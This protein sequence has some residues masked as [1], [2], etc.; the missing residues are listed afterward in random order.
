MRILVLAQGVKDPGDF[1]RHWVVTGQQAV[2]HEVIDVD[3]YAMAAVFGLHGME[4]V[5]LEYARAYVPDVALILP[6]TYVEARVCDDLR[7]LGVVLV[8]LRFDDGLQI[9]PG[10]PRLT[11]EQVRSGCYLDPHC[12]L[13]ITTCRQAVEVCGDAGLRA[14]R[15]GRLPIGW[16]AFSAVPGPVHPAITFIGQ[17]KRGADGDSFRIQA[18]RALLAAGLPV[19]VYGDEWREVPGMEAVARPTLGLA[20]MHRLFRCSAVSLCLPGKRAIQMHSMLKYR[21]LEIAACGGTQVTDW[22]PELADYFDVE[23]DLA[24]YSDLAGLV[25]QAGHYLA[26]P[27]A[28]AEKGRRARAACEAGLGWDRW[29]QDVAA[30]LQDDGITLPASSAPAVLTDTARAMLA[31]TA[32]AMGH[33]HESRGETD[34][35]IVYFEEALGLVPE[36]HGALAGLAR[37]AGATVG[38]RQLWQAATRSSTYVRPLQ[39]GTPFGLQG[40]SAEFGTAFELQAALHWFMLARQQGELEEAAAA[41]ATISGYRP[42]FT[43]RAVEQWVAA[44]HVRVAIRALDDLLRVHPELAEAWRLRGRVHQMTGNSVAARLDI[45]QA[46]QLAMHP[47]SYY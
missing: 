26:H 20:E 4:R 2:G 31:N 30:M 24:T 10:A 6:N 9:A 33:V 25:A 40:L 1:Y 14:P 15:Y 13:V 22:C 17:P 32:L 34:V 46:Y 16:Q 7:A 8:S 43:L 23:G 18:V 45:D 28:A 37:L 29:W 38:A 42:Y 39:L 27:A 5:I 41:L 36:D 3:T 47:A 44:G 19:E 21:T 35:A 12:D 11:P